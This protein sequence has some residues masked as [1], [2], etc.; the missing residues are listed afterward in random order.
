MKINDLYSKFYFIMWVKNSSLLT[1]F[2]N[3]GKLT[4][5]ANLTNLLTSQL[6]T[7]QDL[8]G[9]FASIFHLKFRMQVHLFFIIFT[10]WNDIKLFFTFITIKFYK[11]IL[12]LPVR[13]KIPIIIINEPPIFL[14]IPKCF[15]IAETF[16]NTYFEDKDRIT[17]G[18]AKPKT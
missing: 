3:D 4:F 2:L 17:K 11:N 1:K 7:S 8:L 15:F 10:N 14:I 13:S 5:A 9:S 6:Q 18:V 12:N 16:A